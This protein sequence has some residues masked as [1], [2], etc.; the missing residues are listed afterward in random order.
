MVLYPYIGYPLILCLMDRLV[1]MTRRSMLFR[2]EEAAPDERWPRVSMLISVYNEEIILER[3]MKNTL[4]LDYP[5]DLLE[6]LVISDGSND[7]TD[8]IVSRYR[9]QGI[10]LRRYEGRIGKTACL[11]RTIPTAAGEIIVFSDANSEYPKNGLKNLAR[12]FRNPAIGF[13]TGYT[14]YRSQGASEEEGAIGIY[15]RFEKYLKVMESS[16]GCCVGADG[17]IFAI[18]KTLYIPLADQDINDLVIPLNII[19]HGSKGIVDGD[20]YCIEDAT[21][22]I[23]EEYQRQV[24]ITARTLRAIFNNADLL[25]PFKYKYFS[26]FLFSHKVSKLVGPLFISLY[27]LSNLVLLGEGWIYQVSG[28]ALIVVAGS[29]AVPALHSRKAFSLRPLKMAREFFLI[30]AAYLAGWLSFIRRKNITTWKPI[31]K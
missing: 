16:F 1:K 14:R 28:V 13:I 30:N 23:Q 9:D 25:N 12:H 20:A 31:R 4:L 6:I 15:A 5:G 2:R 3:K 18:R 11:N 27:V 8:E 21:E 22:N 29:A 19:R 7:R 17:A 24:R 10:Q 26:F